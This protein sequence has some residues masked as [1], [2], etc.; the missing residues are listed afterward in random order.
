MTCAIDQ[1]TAS[2]EEPAFFGPIIGF[3]IVRA[4]DAT[5]TQDIELLR[6]C[7]NGEVGDPGCEGSPTIQQTQ[8][9]NTGSAGLCPVEVQSGLT[10]DS[11][12]L[13]RASGALF[14][15]LDEEEQDINTELSP[16]SGSGSTDISPAEPD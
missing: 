5:C 2:A 1:V 7:V 11:A 4:C 13:E 16:E 3:Q 6:E 8:E 10:S 15:L 12:Q 9:C 14:L